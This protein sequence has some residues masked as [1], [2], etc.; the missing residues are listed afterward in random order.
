MSTPANPILGGYVYNRNFDPALGS[1][2]AA[3]GDLAP[4]GVSA[5]W[6]CGV[7]RGGAEWGGVGGVRRGTLHIR[8]SGDDGSRGQVQARGSV[9]VSC[10]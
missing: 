6:G 9:C 10:A 2:A 5:P 3:L 1:N 4:E 7:G 8:G